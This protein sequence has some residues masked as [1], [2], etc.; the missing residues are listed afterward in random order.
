[1]RLSIVTVTYND[2]LRLQATLNSIGVQTDQDF[3]YLVIDGASKDQTANVVLEFQSTRPVVFI[4][5]PDRGLY[6]AMNKGLALAKGD[7][8][9]FLNAGDLLSDIASVTRLNQA[10]RDE[11]IDAVF[12]DVV[13]SD[14][15]RGKRLKVAHDVS[16][17]HRGLPSSHQALVL[18]RVDC[19]KFPFDRGLRLAA[20]FD[21]GLRIYNAGRRNWVY[22]PKPFSLV[23]A[24][25]LSD[26]RR[27]DARLECLRVVFKSGTLRQK[28][29]GCFYQFKMINIDFVAQFTRRV[30]GDERFNRLT[31]S[32]W[33]R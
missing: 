24:G 33:N 5:E 30:I 6:D 15:S 14:V 26:V 20:D 17:I 19:L 4:S 8:V 9:L 23:T 12:A 11:C 27:W 32:R 2:A 29:F 1:L 21:M 10:L 18:R 7:Y 31:S 28:M 22:S 3:E 16:L 13:V 25:G